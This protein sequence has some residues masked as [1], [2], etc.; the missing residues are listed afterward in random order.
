MFFLFLSETFS[1]P[2]CSLVC[3][4]MAA[5]CH[6]ATVLQKNS[7]H[8]I[9]CVRIIHSLWAVSGCPLRFIWSRISSDLSVRAICKLVLQ[10][11][12]TQ[13]YR[14]SGTNLW[15]VPDSLSC[16]SHLCHVYREAFSHDVHLQ[17]F[18]LRR[19]TM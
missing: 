6:D 8:Y 14:I 2:L 12:F 11:Q 16:Y 18:L 19:R 10:N 4:A 17:L 9:L 7:N 13:I 1:C 3:N 5:Y 15:L